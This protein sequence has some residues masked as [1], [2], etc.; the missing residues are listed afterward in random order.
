MP[1]TWPAESASS[2]S[3]PA[4]GK[5]CLVKPG[6]QSGSAEAAAKKH[7]AWRKL[8]QP[9]VGNPGCPK[10]HTS[11]ES[12]LLQ[13]LNRQ[14]HTQKSNLMTER[15]INKRACEAQAPMDS[16]LAKT[17]RVKYAGVSMAVC[18]FRILSLLQKKGQK[19]S[20]KLFL[21]T[22]VSFTYFN[23]L[24]LVRVILDTQLLNL[25]TLTIRPLMPIIET[26]L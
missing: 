4:A 1:E 21:A 12:F 13:L 19:S 3:S 7:P 24:Q 20:K 17:R 8:A 23:H 11:R 26:T 15:S 14:T 6:A 2:C 25:L 18:D 22:L 9:K 16:C 5:S 10:T